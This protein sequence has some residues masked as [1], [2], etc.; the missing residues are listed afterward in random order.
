M[1][2]NDL[3]KPAENHMD[4]GE[5]SQVLDCAAQAIELDPDRIEG[6]YWRGEVFRRIDADEDCQKDID[7]LLNCN[8]S[9][10]IHFAYQGWAYNVKKEKR[11]DLAIEKCSEALQRDA[12]LKEAY[13][14]RAWAY[15]D[16]RDYKSALEDCDKAIELDPKYAF[17]YDLRGKIFYSKGD[18]DHAIEAYNKA[19]ELD[20]KYDAA[21][22]NRVN[23][24]HAK[25]DNLTKKL[26]DIRSNAKFM[27]DL[28]DNI[29]KVVPF[30][31]AGASKPYGYHTWQE[32]L[33]ELLEM[34]RRTTRGEVD[35]EKMTEIQN[36]IGKRDYMGA[37]NKMDPIFANISS[38]VRML[39]ERIAEANPITSTSMPSIIS[40]YLHLFPSKKYLT[41]NYNKVLQDILELKGINAK[42]FYPTLASK[43]DKNQK[44][45]EFENP[46]LSPKKY[47][48]S[49][50]AEET[51]DTSM[52][53]YLH[54]VYDEPD[55]IVLSKIHYDDYYGTYGDIKTYLRKF[56]P[57][58]IFNIYHNS[59]FLYIGCGMAIEH[60]RI[61]EILKEFYHELP[62]SPPSYAL[63]NIYDFAGTDVLFE[64]GETQS[65]NEQ[66]RLCE[67]LDEKEEDLFLNMNVRVIWYF[68]SKNS[69]D[70]HE[71]AKRQL[72]KYILG[73]TRDKLMKEE[74]DKRCQ[75]IKNEAD[76]NKQK[77]EN[78]QNGDFKPKDQEIIEFL[79]NKINVVEIDTTKWSISFP[80]YKIKDELIEGELYKI[81]LISENS[82][83]YLSDEGATYEELN[84]I[85]ELKEPDVIKNLSAILKRYGC[86][87]QSNTNAL[88]I[89]CTLQDI[90][91][92]MSR[93]I[94]TIS[95]MLNMKIFY[96]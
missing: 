80:M 7:K 47:P 49:F 85:F 4:A 11:S 78:Q 72:L 58:K 93:L 45:R 53:Y 21:H 29:A 20:P 54:G 27:A 40:E 26:V 31:G 74:I 12:N 50:E 51:P 91:S 15:Y 41:T 18:Y 25:D 19:I 46:N 71:S 28:K 61:L 96:V 6:Y 95:F 88:T 52:I 75:K 24:Y 56:L 79:Q 73:E 37:I 64:D 2:Y 92:K 76:A 59:I 87:K 43:P 70:G 48:S 32:L 8:P 90:H 30:F 22:D 38:A 83:F 10:A 1:I 55:S 89:N 35:S 39:F 9:N 5:F 13:Y 65:E 68:A 67:A 60:D 63:L 14:F 57:S 23:A 16:Q 36:C 42:S 3:V 34:R 62:S 66:K 82:E 33:Q 69:Q 94:Q 17:V 44:K 81:Y 86:T 84:E 77:R